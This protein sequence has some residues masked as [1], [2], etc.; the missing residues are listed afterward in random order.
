MFEMLPAYENIILLSK[1]IH[2]QT[3][4]K[5]GQNTMSNFISYN[6]NHGNGV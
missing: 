2:L 5:D 6:I 1:T 4:N 3:Q